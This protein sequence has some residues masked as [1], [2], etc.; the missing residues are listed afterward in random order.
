MT[1]AGVILG[2]AAYMSPE[3]A[4]GRPVDKRADIWAFG[5]VLF[6]MLTGRPVFAGDTIPET[7]AAVMRDEP[8]SISCRRRRRLSSGRCWR[9]ASN[10]IPKR[11]LRDIGEARIA[12]DDA[13]ARPGAVVAQPREAPA[14]GAGRRLLQRAVPW[15]ITVAALA[16]AVLF[17][18]R[19]RRR[20]HRRVSSSKS[21]RL[22]IHSF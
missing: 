4:K 9:A 18:M 22:P 20:R 8:H 15:I 2:T 19:R 17:A 21:L 12:L 13:V 16:A 5:C 7:L 14:A 10:A 1:S 11:R 3:Q 6:E